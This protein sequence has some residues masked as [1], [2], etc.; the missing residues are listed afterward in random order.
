MNFLRKKI[1]NTTVFIFIFFFIYIFSAFSLYIFSAILLMNNKISNV[2]IVKN[3]QINFYNQLGYRKIWQTQKE[4]VE[5]DK[6]LIF[7]P[8]IGKC[9]FNNPEFFT[10]LNFDSGGRVSGNNFD[11]NDTANDNAIGGTS[12]APNFTVCG[13]TPGAAYYLLHDAFNLTA[14][15]YGISIY[16]IVLD[17]GVEG[18]ALEVCYGDTV[19]LFLGI[20]NYQLNGTWSETTPTLGLNDNLF[21]TNGLA[22]T[23]YEF[24]YTMQD[25][26]ATDEANAYVEIFS[27]PNAGQGGTINVCL[28]EP[29]NLLSGLSGVVDLTGAWTNPSNV[30]LAGSIDTSGTA[31]GTFNYTYTASN[32]VCP[33]ESTTVAVVVNSGCDFTAGAN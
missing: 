25:G 12:L 7:K 2:K 28:N 5:F 8:N 21:N 17:A 15:N 3:Y 26:C 31:G 30:A 22:S 13:L 24:T 10:E 1:F 32:G 20:A 23:N 16:E 11:N 14:G 6:D 4:C 33:D 19:N 18:E 29:F 27:A 9:F